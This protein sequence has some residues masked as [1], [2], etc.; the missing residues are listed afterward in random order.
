MVNHPYEVQDKIIF[1]AVF[2]DYGL[3]N[4]LVVDYWGYLLKESGDGH[5][6]FDGSS[7]AIVGRG[8]GVMRN[9]LGSGDFSGDGKAD[10]MAVRTDGRLYLYRGDGHGNLVA[11]QRVGNG[12]AG[13]LT[14]FS[15]G[16][17]SGD[18]K[19]DIMAVGKDGG[20][21]LY[22]GNGRGG[23]TAAGQRIGSGWGNF[24]SVISTGDFSGDRKS[25]V[26]ALTM[27]ATS[28][29]TAATAWGAGPAQ[30]RRSGGAGPSSAE[31]ETGYP[32]TER[33]TEY[34]PDIC[35]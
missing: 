22:R 11:G 21:Y 5:G 26:L 33:R 18:G 27:P 35:T 12:W 23:L 10:V 8:W 7:R 19:S 15:P 14:V 32:R 3:P 24:I 6:G 1:S 20:L 28:S 17:F 4:V 34:A 30:A 31:L 9:V 25:D 16:D 29:C 2:D 13:F